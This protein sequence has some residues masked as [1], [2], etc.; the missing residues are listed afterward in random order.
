[1]TSSEVTK[2]RFCALKIVAL[3]KL[4]SHRTGLKKLCLLSPDPGFMSRVG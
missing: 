1:M 3:I 4:R 2:I